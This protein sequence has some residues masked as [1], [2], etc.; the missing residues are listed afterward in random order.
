MKQGKV[1]PQGTGYRDILRRVGTVSKDTPYSA[2]EMK[3][4]ATLAA[5]EGA[6]LLKNEN[7]ALPLTAADTV[8]VFGSRQL[9]EKTFSEYGYLAGGAGSGAAWSGLESYPIDKIKEK[10]NQGK[11]IF[12]APISDA[13]RAE[14]QTY[15]PSDADLAAAKDAG[16]NKAV[17]IL[18]RLEGE[19]GTE[20]IFL[21]KEGRP[22][23]AIE[24]GEWYLSEAEETII[25][26]LHATFPQVIVVT[27]TGS[28]MDTNWVK[29]G[30]DGKQVADAVLFAWYGGRFS[31]EALA[32]LLCGD[33]TP[34]GKLAQTAA[35][36]EN[37][38][39]TEGFYEFN[40]TNYTEDVLVGY[41]YFETFDPEHT[42]INYE[43]GY[44]LSYTTFG[45]WGEMCEIGNTD[46]CI[47]VTVS[48]TGT[49]AGKEVVQVYFSA[50]QM[51]TGDAKLSKPAKEL[52]GFAKTPLLQPG[53]SAVV[54]VKFPIADMASYD[55]TGVTG[56]KAAWVLEAGDYQLYMGTSVKD[57]RPVGVYIQNELLVTEQLSN[58]AQSPDLDK[59]L[60]AD[61]SYET[62]TPPALDEFEPDEFDN[63]DDEPVVY[64][65]GI[66]TFDDVKDGK[67]TLDELVAQFTIDELASFTTRTEHEGAAQRSCIGGNESTVEKY[68]VPI[69]GNSDGPLGPDTGQWSF[70][71]SSA[72]GC[73]FNLDLAADFGTLAAKFMNEK[74]PGPRFWLAPSMNLQR[75][76]LCGRN[77]EYYSEDPLVIGLMGTATALRSQEL[78]FPVTGKVIA[79]NNKELNRGSNDSRMSERALREIYLRGFEMLVKEGKTASLMIAYNR[80][81]GRKLT[82]FRELLVGII[83][84]E[85]GWDGMYM[86]DWDSV[87]PTTAVASFYGG[88]NTFMGGSQMLNKYDTILNAYED[89]NITRE[90]LETNAK[91]VI[92][93]IL[94][95]YVPNFEHKRR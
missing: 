43:F 37:Y 1:Y 63:E 30:I 44:G 42:K 11:F 55:D 58:K 9:Y 61:G 59:R 32:N 21:G 48:N 27:N 85:W 23:N 28:L 74:Y 62:L 68:K 56:N 78:G 84:E 79:A 54:N 92:R 35:P 47:N 39:T 46:I 77:F 89:G 45:L 71:G 8:A 5:E 52:A 65:D 86:T 41:R 14:P 53:E 19:G 12:Y 40:Y 6:V 87:G 49:R 36:I 3:A 91:Y 67:K 51:G 81:N 13:Y 50:P 60:L 69:A 17:Y 15:V 76:P 33:A 4:A 20:E 34:S 57:L 24:P 25:K 90:M 66:V 83:R 72:L 93:A 88:T 94:R 31:S 2:G 7:N 18:S 38:P 73:S 26:R 75:N 80:C 82:T 64:P 22:D 29:D 95:A 10:A 16:V 70:P